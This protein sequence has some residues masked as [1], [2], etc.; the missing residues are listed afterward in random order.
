[1]LMKYYLLDEL[2]FENYKLSMKWLLQLM[3]QRK[4]PYEKK[5]E[6][7]FKLVI[8]KLENQKPTEIEDEPKKKS[9]RSKKAKED[10]V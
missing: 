5:V 10:E 2:S 9:S 4:I 7:A 8:E 1:M 3:Q 6:E